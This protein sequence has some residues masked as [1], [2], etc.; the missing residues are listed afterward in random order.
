[1][2]RHDTGDEACM[3]AAAGKYDAEGQSAVFAAG[4]EGDTQI[5][6]LQLTTDKTGQGREC[7]LFW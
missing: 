1:M 2:T 6:N 3:N 7:V 5:Y 4:H